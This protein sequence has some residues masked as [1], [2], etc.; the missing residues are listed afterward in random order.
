MALL[1]DQFGVRRVELEVTMFPGFSHGF[2]KGELSALYGR[3][4]GDDLFESCNLRA[5]VGAEF[6]S[7]HWFYDISSTRILIRSEA[8]QSIEILDKEVLHLLQETKSFLTPRRLPFLIMDS[9]SIRGA[10]P[11]S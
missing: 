10:V 5:N 2:N 7:E 4:N 1:F 11:E 6:E 9:I 8:F 3:L